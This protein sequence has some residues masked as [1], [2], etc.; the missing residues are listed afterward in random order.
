[1]S[2]PFLCKQIKSF[3]FSNLMSAFMVH[4]RLNFEY[5]EQNILSRICVGISPENSPFIKYTIN[6]LPQSFFKHHQAPEWR[7]FDFLPYFDFTSKIIIRYTVGLYINCGGM[8]AYI[9]RAFWS[10]FKRMNGKIR[11]I[12]CVDCRATEI[13][14][15][16]Q[17]CHFFVITMIKSVA[18]KWIFS[19][20]AL[21][22]KKNRF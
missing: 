5:F 20:R 22:K 15:T 9:F 11:W 13:V 4:I 17:Y 3:N 1:M 2:A 7:A 10:L 18:F 8:I 14:F 6:W 12:L 16:F 19:T 21:N